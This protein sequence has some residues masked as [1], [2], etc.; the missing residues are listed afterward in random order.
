MNT[1]ASSRPGSAA[2]RHAGCICSR[3]AGARVGAVDMLCP[4]HGIEP[5]LHDA[6]DALDALRPLT[7]EE[8][9]E[10]EVSAPACDA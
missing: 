4:L 6:H 3:R 10:L 2:A 9:G 1:S 5:V 7:A 8:Q